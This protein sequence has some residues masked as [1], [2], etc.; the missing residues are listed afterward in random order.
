[1]KLFVTVTEHGEVSVYMGPQVAEEK[2][3]L[4]E[5][6]Q[7]LELK[8][9]FPEVKGSLELWRNLVEEESFQGLWVNIDQ[10]RDC[11]DYLPLMK[12]D[13]ETLVK[14]FEE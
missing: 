10:D 9:A 11:V 4:D 8:L 1:M 2:P 13:Y 5:D 14:F 6:A 12:T 7:L 3:E